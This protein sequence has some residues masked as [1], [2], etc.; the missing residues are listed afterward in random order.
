MECSIFS[1][2]EHFDSKGIGLRA[3]KKLA[4]KMSNRKIVKA[5]I[6][7]TSGRLLDNLYRI[8]KDYAGDKKE[9][10]KVIKHLIKTVI[11]I[12][13]LYRN[14]KL[15]TA[16][17]QTAEEFKR[18]FRMVAMTVISF[19][20]V[21]FTFDRNFLAGA[22]NECCRLLKNLVRNHLTEK[23]LDRIDH[24][25]QFFAAP[26]FLETLFLPDGP[27][28]ALLSKMVTDLNKLLEEGHL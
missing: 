2:A 21:D 13:I 8:A 27:H 16:D 17:M 26:H 3:Q 20:E 25:F 18:K 28:K 24:V 12:G 15:T 6:D 10:E 9:A 4:G 7:D 22:L 14:D 23:S 1:V 19:F 11:K 5:F